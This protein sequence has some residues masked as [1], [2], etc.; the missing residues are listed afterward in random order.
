[1]TAWGERIS[2][3]TAAKLWRL[4]SEAALL[5]KQKSV[6]FHDLEQMRSRIGHLHAEF[7][8][9]TLHALAIKANPLVEVLRA[10]LGAGA[11][12]E[13]ASQEEVHLALAAGCPAENIVFDSPAKTVAELAEALQLGLCLNLDNFDELERVA[14]LIAETPST[15]TIGLRVNPEVGIGTISTTSVASR[16]SKFGL[17]LSRHR[18][19]IVAAF[20]RYPWLT[21]LHIHVGSQG[22]N[23][24][25]LVEAARRVLALRR[26]IEDQLGEGRITTLDLGGGLPVAYRDTDTPPTLR[27][28]LGQLR[29][30]AAELFDPNLRLITE[31]GRSL[32]AGCGVAL[33][34]VEYV[35]DSL[36]VIHLGADMFLRP[37]YNP[38]DW[39]HEFAVCTGDGQLK[40]GPT[41]PTTIGGPLCFGGDIL[42]R[43][44]SLPP[45]EPGDWIIIRDVGGYTLGMWSRH[46]SR[47]LPL[48]LGYDSAAASPFRILRAAETPADVV[49]FWSGPAG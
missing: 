6:V 14:R 28:Y 8:A 9:N 32:Q 44:I 33:S 39:H 22:C 13:A 27:E 3:E 11:G 38:Q 18:E 31:F 7:P 21:G 36:I 20:A 29:E 17:S 41:Q 34:R 47:G 23:L 4:A 24:E 49:R 5:E 26:E 1:M 15:S 30:H 45:I 10:A 2:A 16:Q 42:A 12:C 25:L 37:V 43:D 35:K 46:C 19:R 40:T 48:V